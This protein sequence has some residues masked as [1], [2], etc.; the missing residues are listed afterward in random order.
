MT[1]STTLWAAFPLHATCAQ[2]SFLG[3][4]WSARPL[5]TCYKVALGCFSC[6][7]HLLPPPSMLCRSRMA[8]QLPALLCLRR[9][10]CTTCCQ[11]LRPGDYSTLLCLFLLTRVLTR[12]CRDCCYP[13]HVKSGSDVGL[14]SLACYPCPY[15]VNHGV[16][17]QTITC[18]LCVTQ[19]ATER[20]VRSKRM[21]GSV[22]TATYKGSNG[23][24]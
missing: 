20:R 18:W 2:K 12:V 1:P 15:H 5:R 8:E 16:S 17:R 4:H 11:G 23:G 3:M 13:E 9:L 6:T 10:P 7:F 24:R 22:R 19:P 14:R 21:G